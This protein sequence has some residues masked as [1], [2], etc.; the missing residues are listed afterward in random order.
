[1]IN[2]DLKLGRTPYDNWQKMLAITVGTLTNV[3]QIDQVHAPVHFWDHM[4]A[5]FLNT[6]LSEHSNK[7]KKSFIMDP[8]ITRC[9]IQALDSH[10]I[11]E[12]IYSILHNFS[13]AASR[14]H[15][16]LLHE[17]PELIQVLLVHPERVQMAKDLVLHTT[18]SNLKSDVTQMAAKQCGWHFSAF[19]MSSEAIAAF[20]IEKMATTL[21]HQTPRLWGLLMTLLVSDAARET[22]RACYIKSE[23]SFDPSEMSMDLDLPGDGSTTDSN[24]EYWTDEEDGGLIFE[25]QNATL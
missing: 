2:P 19:N 11:Y 23:S 13:F 16:M 10:S 14:T 4:V 22:C 9:V 6:D 3:P 20:P 15:A 1:V 25:T 5:V 7:K 12:F 17:T 21:Q 8:D 24:N 18:E